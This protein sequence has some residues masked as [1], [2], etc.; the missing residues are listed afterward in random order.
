MC[1]EEDS[2]MALMTHAYKKF[3]V[4]GL[5]VDHDDMLEALRRLMVQSVLS[6]QMSTCRIRA[7]MNPH[8]FVLEAVRDTRRG[9]AKLNSLLLTFDLQGRNIKLR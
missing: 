4:Q 3:G 8:P 9:I 2:H 7:W 5:R 6:I 1:H